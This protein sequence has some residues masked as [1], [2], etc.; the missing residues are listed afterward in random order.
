M[1]DRDR[2]AWFKLEISKLKELTRESKSDLSP[3][4]RGREKFRF[5]IE[6]GA[7]TK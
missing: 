4:W 7:K 5:V 1:K 6:L 2:I 3:K